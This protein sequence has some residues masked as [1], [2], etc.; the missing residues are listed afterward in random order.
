MILAVQVQHYLAAVVDPFLAA[1]LACPSPYLKWLDWSPAGVAGLERLLAVHPG[2]RVIGRL[3]A[4]PAWSWE[5]HFEATVGLYHRYGHLVWAWELA[6]EPAKSPEDVARLSDWTLHAISA[7]PVDMRLV[8]GNFAEGNPSGTESDSWG[9]RGWERFY[10]AMRAAKKRGHLLGVH[11][12]DAPSMRTTHP[13]RCGRL[14]Q[15]WQHWP[16]DLKDIG[17]IIGELGID[18]GVDHHEGGHVPTP[19]S[20]WRDIEGLGEGG[21]LEQ[22]QWFAS[23]YQQP[24]P[25]VLAG[26]AFLLSATPG[27]GWGGFDL[28]GCQRI[29]EWM[30]R[31]AGGV[32]AAPQDEE[33]HGGRQVK[34]SEQFPNEYAE[35][36]AAG[37]I[38][39][40]FRAH[41]LGIGSLKPTKE[42]V[43]ILAGQVK[44]ASEQLAAVVAK[45]PFE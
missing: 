28:A 31:Q 6:N 37:G 18:R 4:P 12:Y 38:E 25:R 30:G 14:A 43:P 45:L 3:V 33:D 34:L 23:L 35:W 44:A 21:Y 13:W 27:G 7:A 41:L 22:L 9:L 40:N 1:A 36:V 10:P 42:D 15:V 24:G 20:G 5:E 39:N 11:E 17:V 8:I 32:P 2:L 16:D 19:Q 26:F 29:A